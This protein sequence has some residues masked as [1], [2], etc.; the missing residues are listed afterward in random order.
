[1][2]A[3]FAFCGCGKREGG[4]EGLVRSWRGLLRTGL[5]EKGK[6]P[7]SASPRERRFRAAPL[8]P[9]RNET[10]AALSERRG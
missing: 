9:A 4:V 7:I 3:F 2:S 8:A 6:F 1:V 5:T 10:F